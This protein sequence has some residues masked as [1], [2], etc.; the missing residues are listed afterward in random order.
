MALAN[1]R[2]GG[3]Q[4][5]RLLRK[6]KVECSTGTAAL[7]QPAMHRKKEVLGFVSEYPPLIPPILFPRPPSLLPPHLYPSHP[8]PSPHP[9]QMFDGHNGTAAAMHCKKELLGFVSE[10]PSLHSFPSFSPTLLP[11]L[12]CS[13]RPSCRSSLQVFDGPNGTAA[14]IALQKGAAGGVRRAQRTAAAM[15]CKKELLEFV[16]EY[17]PGG[18]RTERTRGRRRRRPRSRVNLRDGEGAAVLESGGGGGGRDAWLKALPMALAKDFS[19]ATNTFALLPPTPSH[20][21]TPPTLPPLP[22]SPR[23]NFSISRLASPAPS[24]TLL[25]SVAQS[26]SDPNSL[27]PFGIPTPG[28]SRQERTATLAIVSGWTVTCAAVGGPVGFLHPPLPPTTRVNRNP[29]PLPAIVTAGGQ[30]SGATAM[31]AIVRSAVRSNNNSGDRVGM[32]SDSGSSG[33]FTGAAGRS[34]SNGGDSVWMDGDSGS[35]EWA[36]LRIYVS[37]LAPHPYT[38]LSP[39]HPASH[40]FPTP[41]GQPSGATATVAIVLG[42]TVTVA[43]VGDSRAILDTTGGG[44]TPLLLDHRLRCR[45]RLGPLRSWPGGLSVLRSI[46]D[47]GPLRSW[48]GGLC[49]SRSIGDVDCGT[50]I[51]PLPHVKQIQV[52]QAGGRVVMALDGPWDAVDSG[53]GSCALLSCP[54]APFCAPLCPSVPLCPFL[55]PSV[56][57]CAPLCPA[58][59][60]HSVPLSLSPGPTGG[61]KGGDGV[62]QAGGRVVMA[63]DG[64]WDAVPQAGGRVVMASD[65]LWDAV[66]QAGG[67]VVMASDGLWDAVDSDK[68]ARRCRG[69]PCTA[70]APLLVKESIKAKGLRDDITVLVES[71][72]AKGLRDD[73]TVLV[74]DLLAASAAADPSA[75]PVPKA[76][77]SK[78]FF[79]KFRSKSYSSYLPKSSKDSTSLP[80]TTSIIVLTPFP[81]SLPLSPVCPLSHQSKS[82]SSYL[83]KSAKDSLPLVQI[84]SPPS[85]PP[86]PPHLFSLLVSL[87]S[88][89]SKSYS[90]YLS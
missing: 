68:A 26:P 18:R 8:S 2:L 49:V 42:W 23:L 87:L 62:P 88:N 51:T 72:K 70:A 39:A 89:Q 43:A 10:Y 66:P 55:C 57:F 74:I 22:P 61:W 73:I 35:N 77:S 20:P 50:F 6:S 21:P 24:P 63:S 5:R 54:S 45:G 3:V 79:S 67:R 65:G 47:L 1:Y 52:P 56:P 48:P 28:G 30:P 33:E 9:P 40:H 13:T 69:L 14:A 60:C 58:P 19:N 71:I 84:P 44:V 27:P 64:L 4:L 83:S 29:R 11:L 16:S 90:S 25:Y 7:Q 12:P 82:Y 81:L 80:P 38:P 53:I 41:G 78:S 59:L 76:P 37:S 15:H 34:D 32:H 36:I 46:G 85:H 17:L 86:P 75:C 31:V